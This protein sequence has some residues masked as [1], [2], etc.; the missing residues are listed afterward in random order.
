MKAV[1]VISLVAALF[2][3]TACSSPDSPRAQVEAY[4]DCWAEHT[5]LE[6]V[7]FQLLQ[8]LDGFWIGRQEQRGAVLNTNPPSI[9]VT[10]VWDSLTARE[11]AYEAMMRAK[12]GTKDDRE[13]ERRL[14]RLDGVCI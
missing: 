13:L 11:E 2:A 9:V 1:A 14:A 8:A 5:R 3:L 4:M 7:D 6:P 10:P 12:L